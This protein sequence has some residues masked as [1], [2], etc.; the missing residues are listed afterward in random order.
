[1]S[2]IG[3]I[4]IYGGQRQEKR[5][6]YNK[7]DMSNAVGGTNAGITCTVNKDGTYSYVGTATNTQINVWLLGGYSSQTILFTLKAGIYTVKD[8]ILYHNQN[9]LKNTF[10][11]TEEIAI[12]GVRAVSATSGQT[13]NEKKYPMLLEGEYTANTMPEYEPFGAMPSLQYP[14][15]IQAV[16][17]N[18]NLFNKDTAKSGYYITNGN[19]TTPDKNFLYQIIEVSGNSDISI[20]GTSK[21]NKDIG[22]VQLDNTKNFIKALASYKDGTFKTETNCKY[23]GVSCRV[24]DR[25]TFKVEKGNKSTNYSQHGQGS[26]EITTSNKNVLAFKDFEYTEKGVTVTCKNNKIHISGTA[27]S[28]FTIF[29]TER[30]NIKDL[31]KIIMNKKITL[32]SNVPSKAELNVNAK[33]ESYYIQNKSNMKSVSKTILKELSNIGIYIG[34]GAATFEQDFDIQ[35]ELDELSNYTPHKGETLT[36]PIQSKMFEGDTF[37]Q[38]GDVWYEKHCKKEKTITGNDIQSV[39]SNNRVFFKIS[40]V[41]GFKK[42]SEEFYYRNIDK[43][44]IESNVATSLT[45]HSLTWLATAK[46]GDWISSWNNP[47]DTNG[48]VLRTDKEFA[49]KEEAIAYFNENPFMVVYELLETEYI[50]CTD[51]Q[52]AILDKIDTYKNGTIITTDNDLCKIQLRYKQD[53][54]KRITE[55]ENQIATQT[56]AESE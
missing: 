55:L 31:N 6:G 17:D 44:T 25:D 53:L 29:L 43:N 41:P 24:V 27:T 21:T 46:K 40:S 10:T 18:V 51:E 34:E 5:E 13:Y 45:G 32:S 14:S 54:E 37:E 30:C 23:L 3:K 33:G 42:I 28:A 35:L 8:I 2:F 15:E 26:V 1:M 49:T 47:N 4:S 52:S 50:K 22:I 9:P 48:F 16:G 38:I 20:S 12:T 19:L 39:S 11:L 7:L 56:V 36:M